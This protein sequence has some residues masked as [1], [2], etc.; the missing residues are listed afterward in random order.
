MS[1][2]ELRFFGGILDKFETLNRCYIWRLLWSHVKR[3]VLRIDEYLSI[4]LKKL[5]KE[6]NED[7]VL[8]LLNKINWLV[9]MGL[10]DKS[11]MKKSDSSASGSQTQYLSQIS[12]ILNDKMFKQNISNSLKTQI[13]NYLIEFNYPNSGD[14]WKQA[15]SAGELTFESQTFKLNKNQRY[16]CIQKLAQ[17]GYEY[18]AILNDEYAKDFS[19]VDINA[20]I[21]VEA[22]I[23]SQASKQ[24]IWD[25]YLIA[26]K[27]KQS[28]FEHSSAFFNNVFDEEVGIHFAEQFFAQVENVESNFHRDYFRAWFLNLVPIFLKRE[29]DLNRLR[30]LK[31]KYETTEKTLFTKLLSEEIDSLESL[32][33]IQSKNAQ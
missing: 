13:A 2:E 32:I 12:E 1:V 31:Q 28:H 27:W 22:S 20:K 8:F 10:I 9:S 4:F 14:F 11:M 21:R 26:D 17:W 33:A 5:G 18:E 7:A 29:A 19:D 30:E 23:N 3:G 16:A 15:A 24:A 25:S 6:S